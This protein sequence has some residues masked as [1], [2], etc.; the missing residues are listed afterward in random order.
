M[1]GL[2]ISPINQSIYLPPF[3]R[4]L[5]GLFPDILFFPPDNHLTLYLSH[6]RTFF[7]F[8]YI[9]IFFSPPP[10]ISLLSFS[11][12]FLF[13]L[14]L[15]SRVGS[16]FLFLSSDSSRELIGETGSHFPLIFVL[17]FLTSFFVPPTQ[18]CSISRKKE[19]WEVFFCF[20][21]F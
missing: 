20:L 12:P 9:L 14:F 8:P 13:N 11:C 19:K 1:I 6:S 5:G 10:I 3:P 21:G 16:R 2:S 15:P 4:F 18:V 7:I 17:L